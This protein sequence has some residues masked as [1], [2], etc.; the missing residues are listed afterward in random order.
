MGI[1]WKLH[2]VFTV[3]LLIIFLIHNSKYRITLIYDASTVCLLIIE[4]LALALIEALYLLRKHE[5]FIVPHGMLIITF[6]SFYYWHL[7]NI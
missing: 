7:L 6:F 3:L 4:W 2:N 1:S 5:I